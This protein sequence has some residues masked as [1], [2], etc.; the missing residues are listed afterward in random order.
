VVRHHLRAVAAQVLERVV[1]RRDDLGEK[2][3][4]AIVE[5]AGEARGARVRQEKTPA[6]DGRFAQVR[7]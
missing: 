1:E 2:R 5:Q 6:E 4:A 7:P 3:R